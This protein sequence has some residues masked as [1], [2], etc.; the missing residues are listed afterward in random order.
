VASHREGSTHRL[1]PSGELDLASR[2]P[3]ERELVRVEQTDA[4]RIELDLAGLT[5]IDCAGLRVVTDAAARSREDG[6]RLRL[7]PGTPAVQRVLEL[8]G[9]V[10]VLPFA[11]APAPPAGP[12]DPPLRAWPRDPRVVATEEARE[13]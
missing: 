2:G 8:T 11:A 4:L 5:F 3:L 12:A 10:A 1:A 6:S 7:R 9:V 13:P